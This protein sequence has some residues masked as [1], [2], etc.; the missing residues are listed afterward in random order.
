[1]DTPEEFMQYFRSNYPGP[2]TLIHDPDWHAPKIYRAA[3]AAS[4]QKESTDP[5]AF[6]KMTADE[7]Q[8]LDLTAALWA[9]FYS[10][11]GTHREDLKEVRLSL[12]LMY[13]L[14][15]L[16]IAHRVNP[17]IWDPK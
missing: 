11:E 4:R 15:A 14:I 7:K 2:N 8:V 16:R 3:I 1:M 13:R 17:E 6:A 5:L 9:K 10:L 12:R